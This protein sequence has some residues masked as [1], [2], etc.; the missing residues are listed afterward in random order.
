MKIRRE[1]NRQLYQQKMDGVSLP[2]FREEYERYACVLRG[3]RQAAAALAEDSLPLG[4]L[5]LSE[6]PLQNA[7]YAFVLEAGLLAR[8]CMEAGLSHDEAHTITALY[9]RKLDRAA[10]REAVGSL[11]GQMCMDLAQRMGEIRKEH[12]VSLHVRRCIDYIYENLGG[13][14]SLPAL[15]ELTGLTP[16]YLSRLFAAETG[17]LLSRFILAAKIDTAQNLLA[18]SELSC[19]GIAASLGFCSQSA[20]T[21]AFRRIT[22]TT[23]AAFRAKYRQRG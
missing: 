15:A 8:L 9:I 3:D 12:T 6:H 7:R 16:S 1:L 21:A 23:P 5:P 19:A 2:R 14:L 4:K 13:D 17:T 18:H 20:L 22:G 10:T 11:Y